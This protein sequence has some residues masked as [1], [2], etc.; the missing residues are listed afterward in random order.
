MISTRSTVLPAVAGAT[1]LL[2]SGCNSI[3]DG[4]TIEQLDIL[5]ASD[6]KQLKPFEIGDSVKLF[7]CLRDELIVRATFTDGTLVN[8]SSRATWSSSDPSVVEVSN[9]DIPV[10]FL[11]GNPAADGSFYEHEILTYGSGTVVPRGTPGQQA[12][13]TARFASLSASIVV[14]IRKPTLRIIAA[15]EADPGAAA[16]PYFLGQGTRQRLTVLMNADGRAAK[17]TDLVGGIANAVNIN[18]LRWVFTA[19]TFVPQDDDVADDTDLWVIDSGA[20]RIATMQV[21]GTDAFVKG[22]KAD[23]MP[24]EVTAES[25]LCPGSID[26]ALRPAASVQVASFYDDPGTTADDRLVLTR[27]AGFI[28][29]G[30]ATEDIVAGTNQRLELRGKLDA[31]GDGSLIVEQVLNNQAGY[32]VRPQDSACEDL[33]EQLG[34]L[35]NSDFSLDSGGSAVPV[36]TAADGDVARARACYPLCVRP[37][38]TLA[39]DSAAVGVGVTVTFT[40]TALNAPADTTVN[41]LFDF[42]D[43]TTQ[44]P[45]ASAVASHAYPDAGAYTATVRLVDPAFP[46]EFL[47]LNAGAVRV[48]AGMAPGAGN[49]APTA[50]LTVSPV[51]GDAPLTVTLG[52]SGSSDSNSGD[53]V[54]VYEFD[55]GDGTPVV[56]QSSSTL[57]HTYF[58]GTGGPFT[59]TLTVYDQSGVASTAASGSEVTVNGVAPAMMLS[60]VIDLRARKGTLCSV[61]L[62]PPVASAPA[63]AAF[64]YPGFRFEAMGSFVAD[65]DTDACTDPVIGTQR[66]TRFMLWTVRPAGVTDEVS[67]IASV[68]STA[69]DF[70]FPGQVLYRNDVATDTVLDVTAVPFS[71]FSSEIVATTTQLTVMPCT[72]CTP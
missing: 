3:G 15:P 25:S 59:P 47:G 56:R 63:E 27:E 9:G 42:G 7:E 28:G 66:V 18:P 50:A 24:Y 61:E 13:I 23:F 51:V 26:P 21:I 44:G 72:G 39:A 70:Q 34:C 58:D 29:S 65:T 8:F 32:V 55:P 45:Q 1:L 33:D 22:V 16:P 46:D 11:A 43:G 12:T 2:L 30:F 40:A 60:E 37:R 49:T 35:A 5:P 62:L 31:N 38:A 71:P 53:S 41:Y 17:A 20:D 67:D 14:E 68:R 4:S 54:T 36:T 57:T 48:L 64:T 19:G 52:G 69:D 6:N 10:V